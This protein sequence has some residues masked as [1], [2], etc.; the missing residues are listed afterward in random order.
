M[1]PPPQPSV[2]RNNWCAAPA[3]VRESSDCQGFLLTVI[4]LSPFTRAFER[5]KHGC[6]HPPEDPI[7]PTPRWRNHWRAP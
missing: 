5:W 6:V 4:R 3:L 2:G 7:N 1:E